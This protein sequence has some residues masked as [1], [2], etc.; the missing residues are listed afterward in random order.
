VWELFALL[1]VAAGVVLVY[2]FSEGF[3]APKQPAEA[4][5]LRVTVRVVFVVTV[6]IAMLKPFIEPHDAPFDVERAF[7]ETQSRIGNQIQ[8][9]AIEVRSELQSLRKDLAKRDE[10][11]SRS[12]GAKRGGPKDGRSAR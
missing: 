9:Q 3:L 2:R 1:I 4:G 6:L 5:K 10:E 12:N 11:K 7:R 8:G